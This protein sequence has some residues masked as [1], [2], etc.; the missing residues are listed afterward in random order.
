[1]PKRLFNLKNVTE[2]EAREVRELLEQHRIGYYE[3]PERFWGFSVPAIWLQSESDYEKAR[4]LLDQYQAQRA[5]E[6]KQQYQEAKARGEAPNV[7]RFFIDHPLRFI[8]ALLGIAVVLY[9]SVKPYLML[10]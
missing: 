5:I 1:M 2:D 7:W 6:Q 9:F 3:T 4:A 8:L 10:S